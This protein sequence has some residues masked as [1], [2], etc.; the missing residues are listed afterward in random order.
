M[1]EFF[2]ALH[3][4]GFVSWFAALFY[5]PRLFIYHTEAFEEQEPKRQILLAQ[6][7]IM[8]NRLYKIIMTPAMVITFVGGFS[9]LHI[10]GIDWL[11]YNAWMHWKLALIVFLVA[12]HFYSKTIMNRLA[13][14]TKVMTSTQFRL[15]NEVT[16]LF[17]VA[18]VLLAVYKNSLQFLYAFAG[19]IVLG[20]ALS[21]GVRFYKKIREGAGG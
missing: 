19:I 9:M 1:F 14:G 20:V 17:L 5:L 16:T 10:R 15:Y 12:Y 3:I 21:L 11:Q 6:F 8:E 7:I 4:I 13:A 2:K 18:I